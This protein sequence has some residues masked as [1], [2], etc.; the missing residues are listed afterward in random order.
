MLEY[1]LGAEA[2][3]RPEWIELEN[4][5]ITDNTGKSFIS[6][7][8]KSA[9]IGYSKPVSVNINKLMLDG[10]Q[11]IINTVQKPTEQ[12]IIGSNVVSQVNKGLRVSSSKPNSIQKVNYQFP[13][14]ETKR[15]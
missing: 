3:N 9:I 1:M 12:H 13:V 5:V 2:N 4:Y 6:E 10:S 15:P 8:R 14:T 11:S 7:G